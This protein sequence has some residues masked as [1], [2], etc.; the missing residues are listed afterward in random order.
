MPM[1]TSYGPWID[2]YGFRF[3]VFI[4][5]CSFLLKMGTFVM[6]VAKKQAQYNGAAS[7]TDHN[8][9]V[10][11]VTSMTPT[12]NP[13]RT[14]LSIYELSDERQHLDPSDVTRVHV[15]AVAAFEELSC[16]TNWRYSFD[17]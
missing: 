17:V 14:A 3:A 4:F 2:R 10:L 11:H 16:A 15:N 9:S 8:L 1:I 6:E 12:A 5:R 13:S 7:I